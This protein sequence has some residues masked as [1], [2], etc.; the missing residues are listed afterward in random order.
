VRVESSIAASA[1]PTLVVGGVPPSRVP[2][3]IATFVMSAIVLAAAFFVL[4]RERH[5]AEMR[6]DFVS[7]VSH[8]LRT[9]LTQIRMFTETLLF[10]RVRSNEERQH[11]L[12]VINEEARRLTN[13][14][15]NVLFLSRGRNVAFEPLRRDCDMEML[16]GDAID[17]FSPLAIRRDVV[18]TA[19]MPPRLHASVDGEAWKQVVTNILDNAVKYGPPGQTVRVQVTNGDGMLRMI[20]DDEGPGI[21]PEERDQIWLRFHRLERDRGGHKTGSGLGLAIVREIVARHGGRCWV[22]D[23]PERGAR[24][25][26]EVPIG[27]SA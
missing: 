20:V 24:F 11:S 14:V 7:G 12:Q 10:D 2:V 6:S 27:M 15:D 16:I 18:I 25:V 19:D 1:V 5:L 3:L 22:E 4:R 9:P 26:V 23:A 13:L 17:A 8:E 21:P